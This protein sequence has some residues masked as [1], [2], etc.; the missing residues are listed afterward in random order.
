MLTKRNGD[1]TCGSL[2]GLE[3]G[4]NIGPLERLAAVRPLEVGPAHGRRHWVPHQVLSV[5]GRA[6]LVVHPGTHEKDCGSSGMH[7]VL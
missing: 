3:E 7:T 6:Q 4:S 2:L 1:N 5:V